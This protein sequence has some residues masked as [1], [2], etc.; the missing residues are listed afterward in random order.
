[1]TPNEQSATTLADLIERT[2]GIRTV[3][4]TT[5]DERGTL[6]SR[7]LTVQRVADNGDLYFIIDREAEWV[8]AASEPANVA[9]VDAD[10][11]WV[12]VAGRLILVDDRALLDELWDPM[13]DAFFPDGKENGPVV[14][15]VQSDRWEYWTAPNKLSQMVEIAR[16]RL[17][18]GTTDLGESGSIET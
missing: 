9:L 14:M 13:T 5:T 18:G 3:M 15:V 2:D 6:S 7:P 12:S 16:A 4:V 17:T 11:T 8:G 1:M 10:T